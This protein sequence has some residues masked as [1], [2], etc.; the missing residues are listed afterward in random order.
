M[1]KRDVHEL[2]NKIDSETELPIP[3][4]GEFKAAEK[5]VETI[6]KQSKISPEAMKWVELALDPFHDNVI[7]GFSGI[8]D[9]NTGNSVVCSVV[10]EKSLVK[11]ASL[12]AGLW[13]VRICT[14]P[15][16]GDVAINSG[17]N[18]VIRGSSVCD[19][20]ASNTNTGN[21]FAISVDYA[22]DGN[23]F[24]DF[25]NALTEGLQLPDN[26]TKGP[27]KVAAMGV[28]TVNT[29]AEIYRQGLATCAR[30]NQ[31]SPTPFATEVFKLAN[32]SIAFTC[33]HFP[34]RTPPR[35]LSEMNLLPGTCAWH[36]MEGAYSVVTLKD[37]GTVPAQITPVYP[38]L[39]AD[40]MVAGANADYFVAL[41]MNGSSLFGGLNTG[42][43]RPSQL[44]GVVPQDMSIQMFTGLSDQT[45]L[46]LRGRWIIER[47]PSDIE[48]EIVVMATPTCPFSPKA[49]ELYNVMVNKLP[50]AVM[51]KENPAGEWFQRV[52]NGIAEVAGPLLG[53]IPHPY[54][55]IASSAA[56]VAANATRQNQPKAL[57]PSPQIEVEPPTRRRQPAP[58]IKKK[59]TGDGNKV[60][61]RV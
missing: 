31:P 30:M 59:P 60:R 12:G 24:P 1:P 43:W 35:N 40:D 55:Q 8:P 17:L 5:K 26:F 36:A 32:A 50:P 11:P 52:V 33:S 23:D 14:Y 44:V 57:P 15:I 56:K 48:P 25:P 2:L 21:M 42:T 49:I 6:V 16:V 22:L 47:Y 4:R 41:P 58:K 10:Q 27:F 39:F 51:F 46:T 3:S 20:S 45:S 38:L 37:I 61:K 29:T 9:Q 53:M 34:V 54:A 7:K 13:K 19:T 18:Q 28:E